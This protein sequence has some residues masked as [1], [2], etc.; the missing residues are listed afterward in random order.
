[1]K[2]RPQIKIGDAAGF[3]KFYKFLLKCQ[4]IIGG[5]KW[6]A[7]DSP[8]SICMLLSKLPGHLKN[9]WNREVYSIRAKHSREPE[10]KDLINYA[11]K[12]TTLVSDPLFSKEAV[13]QYLDKRD[14]KIDKRIRVRS[15]TIR[16]EEQPKNKP[17]KDTKGKD[18]CIMCGACHDL[19]DYSTF[20]S[21]TFENW[22]KVLFRNK[23]CYGC[24]GCISKD[25]SAR[26]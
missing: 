20:M 2:G 26:N 25:N 17:D 3:P 21:K 11:N 12:G 5:N 16:S 23:L 19:D 15:Y 18:N 8:E 13:E 14:I 7:L 10:L 22:S 9:R 6:N 1:M 24:Y 4:S